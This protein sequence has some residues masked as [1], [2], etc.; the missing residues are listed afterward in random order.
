MK[1]LLREFAN[2][3]DI[4]MDEARPLQSIKSLGHSLV[5]VFT[6][7][8]DCFCFLFTTYQE[9]RCFRTVIMFRV[10]LHDINLVG[11][12][13]WVIPHRKGLLVYGPWSSS[14]WTGQRISIT[15]SALLKLDHGLMEFSP[16]T[17]CPL[18]CGVWP[19]PKWEEAKLLSVLSVCLSVCQSH[20]LAQKLTVRMSSVWDRT[21]NGR[22][23]LKQFVLKPWST[24]Y[25]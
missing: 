6:N 5:Y 14:Y 9:L 23:R 22:W 12:T 18:R 10:E 1:H 25:M 11:K 8:C 17:F 2:Q 19:P 21:V 13:V 7:W 4:K 24:M 3:D 16:K 15:A 20:A